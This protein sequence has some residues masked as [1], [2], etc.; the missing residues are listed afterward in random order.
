MKSLTHS[1][2][3]GTWATLLLPIN[4]DESIDFG[5][6]AEQIDVLLGTG[7]QGIYTNG[8][9]AEFYSQ[10]EEE[11][12]RIH[13]LLTERCENAGMP[14][15][16]GANHMS[17]QVSL[18]RLERTTQLKPSAFQIVLP[19]WYPLSDD[20]TIA[21]LN[22]IAEA[23]DSIALVLYNPPH[24]KR[25]L[26][27]DI[28]GRICREIPQL[29]GIKVAPPDKEWFDAVQQQAPNLA[30]FVPGHH[31]ATQYQWGA[32][33]SYSNVACLHP[34]GAVRWYELIKKDLVAGLAFERRI[35]EF[36]QRYIIPPDYCNAAK[37]K[38][39]AAIGDWAN[40]GTRLRWPYRFV[41][42]TE[43][44]RLYP[45]ARQALPELFEGSS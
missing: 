40:V 38:F 32:A 4:Q 36:L 12:D 23:S 14:F 37:D 10:S 25:I 27:P 41:P 16:I 33:G 24:A 43:A 21:F 1:E 11:F 22:R 39:M 9:A 18:A 2:L 15:Q 3:R 6:L 45:I 30:I 8:T 13:H 34:A 7:V 5:R 44:K 42:E 35:Q 20:E 26:G 17:A 31:L 29:I 19:D 28:Y